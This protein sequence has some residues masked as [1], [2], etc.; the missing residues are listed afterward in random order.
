M[1]DVVK[2]VDGDLT[3]DVGKRLFSSLLTYALDD[4]LCRQ[5]GGIIENSGA[6]VLWVWIYL[7]LCWWLSTTTQENQQCGLLASAEY[8]EAKFT[9]SFSVSA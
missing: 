2:H 8:S 3:N 5:T 1:W 7:L 9:V 6:T 4:R